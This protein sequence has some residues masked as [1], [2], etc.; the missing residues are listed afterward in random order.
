MLV[1]AGVATVPGR[2]FGNVHAKHTLRLS[3]ATSID[4]LEEAVGRISQFLGR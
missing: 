3:Y 1:Q 2:D 4:R